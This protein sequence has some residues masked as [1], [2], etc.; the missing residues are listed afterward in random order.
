MENRTLVAIPLKMGLLLVP[1]GCGSPT[2]PVL[3]PSESCSGQPDNAIVTF[4]DA[5]LQEATSLAVERTRPPL[6]FLGTRDRLDLTCGRIS[7]LTS[8]AWFQ[9]PPH[10]EPS[11]DSESHEPDGAQPHY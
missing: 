7:G 2:G 11:G 3:L 10:R 9:P 5:G 8:L 6:G 4:E 1:L